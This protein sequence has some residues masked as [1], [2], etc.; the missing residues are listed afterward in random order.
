MSSVQKMSQLN[1]AETSVSLQRPAGCMAATYI[2]LFLVCAGCSACTC[3]SQCD[4]RC[5][6]SLGDERRVS[7]GS[8]VHQ[9][10]R[11]VL[12]GGRW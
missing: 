9:E 1:G 6:L 3:R 10:L 11:A 4:S 7:K 2:Y 8:S 5:M 12:L